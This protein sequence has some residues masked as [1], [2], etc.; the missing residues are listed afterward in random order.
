MC[1]ASV[2]YLPL[3]FFWLFLL[4]WLGLP[5][6]LKAQTRV[7]SLV[8]ERF[9][10]SDS[11]SMP[12]FTPSIP[13]GAQDTFSIHMEFEGFLIKNEEELKEL[14]ALDIVGVDLVYTLFPRGK[15]FYALNFQRFRELYDLY[16]TLFFKENIRWR[17]LGQSKAL[18]REEAEGLYHGFVLYT[19][20][21]H[22][23][24]FLTLPLDY[25]P[26]A[27][28]PRENKDS[29]DYLNPDD[30]TWALLHNYL[31]KDSIV[32]QV[33]ERNKFTW[34][35]AQVVCDWTASMYPYGTQLLIWLKLH[36]QESAPFQSFVFFNDGDGKS[37]GEKL[38]G[39]TGGVHA[40][41]GTQLEE[42]LETM[43]R[44][45]KLGQGGYSSEND[46]EALLRAGSVCKHCQE[47]VLIADGRSPIRDY[48][49]LP[50]V[51]ERY[52]PGKKQLRIILCG[53][54]EKISP[55][56]FA[57]AL[58]TQASLHTME[59]DLENLAQLS[60]GTQFQLSG[61]LYRV[62]PYGI[63]PVLEKPRRK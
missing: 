1:K 63:E 9:R 17:R 41:P 20:P 14:P 38:I 4:F 61:I 37:A 34:E 5:G 30:L 58:E 22:T 25:S 27:F 19:R 48:L 60:P 36:S 3:S 28:S 12:I 31:G 50:H 32:Y 7:D 56:Y 53:S 6:T 2:I 33:L 45:Q 10:Q 42:I 40:A 57:L 44:T 35:N 13:A 24:P 55:D 39:Q 43:I 62:G 11:I 29:L 23:M 59:E 8:F 47:S 18:S 16:P 49:L 51:K 21:L 54:S 15:N 26:Q 52:G 46:L